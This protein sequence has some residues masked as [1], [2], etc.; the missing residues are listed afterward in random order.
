MQAVYISLPGILPSISR[1]YKA[2]CYPF[3]P[4]T[5]AFTGSM[6]TMACLNS[7]VHSFVIRD[8]FYAHLKSLPM[9]TFCLVLRNILVDLANLRSQGIGFFTMQ[10][11]H[12]CKFPFKVSC[13]KLAFSQALYV[14]CGFLL[15]SFIALTKSR[16][17]GKPSRR[18][19]ATP[20]DLSWS[21]ID[22]PSGIPARTL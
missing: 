20:L 7:T 16:D 9:V 5:N 11:P 12:H 17:L 10:S 4:Q 13:K 15:P 2:R 21:E 3:V 18:W 14:P 6:F 1:N 22:L 8:V 19:L